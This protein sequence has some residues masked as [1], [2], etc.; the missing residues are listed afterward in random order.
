MNNK[1]R[2]YN[3][4]MNSFIGTLVAVLNI[5]INFVVRIVIVRTLGDEINGLHNMF[6]SLIN[7][8]AIVE[9]SFSTAM[10]INL[11][12]PMKIN[13]TQLISK[14]MALYRRLYIL[15]AIFFWFIGCLVCLNLD[16]FIN[17]NI[18][19]KQ[20]RCFFVLFLLSFIGNQLTY[21]YRIILFAEQKNRI[22]SLVTVIS[23]LIFRCGGVL[24]AALF[25]N[26]IF[27]LLFLI[28]EK[29]FSNGICARYVRKT[30]PDVI[31]KKVV[32]DEKE[33][34]DKVISS[35]KPLLRTQLANVIQNSSQSIVIGILL[36]NIAIV[37]Y[38]GNYQL[39]VGAVGLLFS[40]I[41]GAFTS[42]FGNLAID[43][44]VD[45][46]YGVYRKALFIMSSLA[47][48]VCSGFLVCI[49][50]FI[51]LAFGKNYLL[52][53]VS[54]L[55]FAV[56]IFVSIINVPIIS[57]QNAMG[58]HKLDEKQM[59]I[60]AI[61]VVLL[62]CLAG[63]FFE[64]EGIL[65]G[66]LMPVIIFTTLNKGRII[67]KKIFMVDLK[68]YLES[69]GSILI[70]AIC[71]CGICVWICSYIKINHLLV[72]ILV[73]GFLVISVDVLCIILL[74]I[75]DPWFWQCKNMLTKKYRQ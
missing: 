9:T 17:T 75:R 14:T 27:F 37:G 48:V 49:Q 65:L 3:A 32:C 25:H 67:N 63:K 5:I 45:H 39:V 53:F 10:I 52:S 54:V 7:V 43:N 64:M 28:G 50:P 41:G 11:Y 4:A 57:I 1:S 23:E 8:L 12:G 33:I 38:Y 60:Q 51:E 6:Q 18:E 61:M 73:K 71:I 22:S 36:G 47:I 21:S 34:K 72:V 69:I 31:W 26:Y 20:V 59:I 42:S 68:A 46:M 58:L 35:V 13:D 19:M 2:T 55:I 15:I 30:H 44:N 40:Q 62:Q 56:N 66:A 24:V 16:G 70:K 74:S 29:L